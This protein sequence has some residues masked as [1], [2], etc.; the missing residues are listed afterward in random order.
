LVHHIGQSHQNRLGYA[1]A[2][3][4]SAADRPGIASLAEFRKACPN[5]IVV[6]LTSRLDVSHKAALWAGADVFISKAEAPER[7]AELV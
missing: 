5:A 7:V 1:A 2:G 3:L 4:G 6:V